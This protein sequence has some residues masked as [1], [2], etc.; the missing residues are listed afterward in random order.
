MQDGRGADRS[1][2]EAMVDR[3]GVQA[4]LTLFI[5][6]M[7]P[8]F[9]QSNLEALIADIGGGTEELV[10]IWFGTKPLGPGE[11]RTATAKFVGI[12]AAVRCRSLL[13]HYRM[14]ARACCIAHDAHCCFDARA[15]EKCSRVGNICKVTLVH[16]LASVS[17]YSP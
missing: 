14:E 7:P 8:D 12:D 5:D 11:H 10:N 15:L 13:Q 3:H 6:K 1:D 17:Y 16:M 4:D 9:T 2:D